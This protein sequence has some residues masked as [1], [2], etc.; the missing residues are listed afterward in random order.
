MIFVALTNS[1]LPNR[2]KTPSAEEI[3][4]WRSWTYKHKN[5]QT[6]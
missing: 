4:G 1:K 6:L 2:S 5:R 3:H